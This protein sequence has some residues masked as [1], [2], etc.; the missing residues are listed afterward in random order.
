MTP[1][2]GRLAL[3]EAIVTMLP[4]PAVTIAGSTARVARTA[5]TRFKV[6]DRVHSSSV[7]SRK[8]FV[9]GVTAP[10]LLTRMSIRPNSVSASSASRPGPSAGQGARGGGAPPPGAKE[11]RGAGR[12]GGA[13]GHDVDAFRDEG[14]RDG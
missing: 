3:I 9:R 1:G 6:S 13:P 4:R 2:S 12:G 11:A 5:L 8:P 10:T 7:T 14:L